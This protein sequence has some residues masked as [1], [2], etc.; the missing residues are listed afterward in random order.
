MTKLIQRYRGRVVDSPGDNILADFASVVDAV[1]CAV[2]VQEVL[3][4]KNANLPEDRR[5]QFRIG[6]NLGDVIEE[7]DRI[8]GDGVN[9]AARIEGLAEGGGICISGS[10]HEQ[11]ENKLALGYEYLGENNVKNISKPIRVYRVLTESDAIRKVIDKTG[12]S[13]RNWRRIAIAVVIVSIVIGVGLLVSLN[14][15]LR[16]SMRVEAAS[17]DKMAYPLPEKPSIAVLP[18]DNLSGDP[19]Q[20]YFSDG[21]TE[22]IITSLSRI[23]RMFVI[24]RNSTF[25]YKGKPV[26]VQKVAEDL[27]VRYIL[28]GG[29][30]RSGGRVRIT[31]QL[32]DAITG[33]HIWSERYDRQM[34]DIFALQD[35]I[36]IKILTAMQVELTEGKQIIWARDYPGSLEAYEKFIKAS[37]YMHR[38]TKQDNEQARRLLRGAIELDTEYAEYAAACMLSGWTNYI[39]VKFGWSKDPEKSIKIAFECAKMCTANY[40]AMERG[41]SLLG[42]VYHLKGR[43]DEAISEV[44]QAIAI[45]PN[46]ADHYSL[47][48]EITSCA[49]RWEEGIPILNKAIRLNPFPPAD[50]FSSLGRSYMMTRR[51]EEAIKTYKK[52]L[53]VNPNFLLAHLGL[54]ATYILSERVAEAKAAATEV[55]RINPKFSLEHFEKTLPFKNKVDID[56]YVAALRKGGLK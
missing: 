40:G 7:G 9:I 13:T 1:Q 38:G 47:L 35:E 10:A 15:Y 11:I 54:T 53:S 2:E 45:G 48:G 20:E 30:Q 55:L 41:H 4:L 37:Y 27:G 56:R 23:P 33:Y 50:Y 22:Q 31:A 24:A 51:Y 16:Q 17:L 3:K 14:F 44:E 21:L 28:E 5:M 18:F 12:V 43:Y 19:E 42:A 46:A 32:I 8:Y 36:T 6:I 25:T 34:E 29:V 26:K 52:S 49:G 39:D